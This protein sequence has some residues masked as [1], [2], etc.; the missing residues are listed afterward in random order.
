MGMI[1][2]AV[3]LSLAALGCENKGGGEIKPEGSGKPGEAPAPTSAAAE[4]KV[5]AYLSLSGAE[6][7]FGVDTKEGIELAIEEVNKAGGPKGKPIKVLFEDDKSNPQEATNKVL[8]L[9]DRD[10][11]VAL[12]GEVASSRSKAGGIVANKKK[13][14]MISPSSTNAEVT[15]IG[16]FV[17]RVCF[18][19]D[20]QGQ[21]G[22]QFIVN[23][24]GKKKVAIFFASDDL[25]SSGLA[26]EFR[27]EA[28]KLGAN[29][30]IEKSFLKTET[31]FT[32]YLNEIRDAKP[33][34]IY[35]PIYYTQMVPIAR[36]AKSSKIPGSMFVG[37]DGWDSDSLLSDA[38]EEMEGA[39]FTN[40][41]APDV[42]WPNTK[43]FIEKYKGRFSREPS[44]LAAM[45][46]DAAKL[47][48]DAMG[49]AKGETP[50]AIRDAIQDTK[51]FQGASGTI[52]IDAERN[53]D[54]PLV[55][56]Q[57]KGKKYTYFATVNDKSA[58]AGAAPSPAAAS[59]SAAAGSASAAA[60]SA[61]AAAAKPSAAA[62]KPSAAAAKPAGSAAAPAAPKK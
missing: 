44:G 57:I 13:V 1:A 54:K 45:G 20:V 56:V 26:K 25:Y 51:G 4:W 15:K 58:G 52:S 62:A 31:N 5:G 18:I 41:Y 24:L 21:M 47:L 61:S 39:Y 43:S 11:V 10:K 36:Q 12:L 40:H 29:I 30:V 3:T 59:A 16:P 46:Y 49:R 27:A 38:G 60:G 33:D 9:I 17:F 32:T 42:P 53:A 48:A 34:L 19:D 37:G 22:A 14:P 7:Q 50:E 2:G 6:T 8:Q 28:K 35:A 55:I 23:S